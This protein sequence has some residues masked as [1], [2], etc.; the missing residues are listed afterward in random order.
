MNAKILF[1]FVALFAFAQAANV[2]RLEKDEPVT[3]CGVTDLLACVGEIEAAWGD[4]VDAGDVFGCIEDIL[5]ASD[6]IN[7]VCD[8][9][10]C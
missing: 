7:C 5:G 1:C 2:M 10:G 9:I 4:C 3:F 6:C 8:V